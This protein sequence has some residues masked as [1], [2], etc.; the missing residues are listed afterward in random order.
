MS[1]S[2]KTKLLKDD[3]LEKQY[4]VEIQATFISSKID[5]EILK[6]QKTYKMDGFRVGKV[7]VETIKK[8]EA[9]GLFLRIAE[10]T[11]NEEIF[12]IAEEKKYQMASRPDVDIK[13][14]QEN[15][16]VI[17]LVTYTLL[18]EIE[19]IDL[20]DIKV[21][22]YK[23]PVLDTDVENALQNIMKNF[24]KWEKVER[25]AKMGDSV[26]INFDG[27]IDGESFAGGKAEDFQL[28]LGSKSFIDNFEEQLVGKKAND[29]VVVKVK[30]P[31]DYHSS[32]V[33]GKNAEFKVKVLEVL[34]SKNEDMTDEFV[35]K[36]FGIENAEKFKEEIRKELVEGNSRAVKNK[37]KDRIF[38]AL[39]NKVSFPL[40]EK[41]V[42]QQF[43]ELKKQQQQQ[44]EK[45]KKTEEIDEKKI[46][47]DAEKAVKLG[48]VLS[49]VG[50]NANIT[51]SENEVNSAIMK[52][53]MSM[54][55]YEQMVVD[56]Y[57]KNKQAVENLRENLLEDKIVNYIID[58]VSKNEKEITA[59]EFRNL[60]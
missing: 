9:I 16:D 6:L 26:K 21:D 53:A 60:K 18:P 50:K 23:I 25:E 28:Q 38:D 13:Q 49:S 1:E 2:I 59:E 37:I 33:A 52:S 48:L 47:E 35:F 29:D 22:S 19:N 3:T 58:N 4:E 34:E 42:N 31:D 43:E 7:P 46:R 10:D 17:F 14:F 12:K 36:N 8:R 15:K 57:K 45:D 41:I 39:L 5:E 20:K 56:F 55:G 44:N 54:R 40:P 27:S 30:F 51:V 11:M 24:I 32:A